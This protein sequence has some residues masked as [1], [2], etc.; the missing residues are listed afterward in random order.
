M[1][2]MVYIVLH[3]YICLKESIG[4]ILNLSKKLSIDCWIIRIV[5]D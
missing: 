3:F 2:H 4:E 5:T 1:C